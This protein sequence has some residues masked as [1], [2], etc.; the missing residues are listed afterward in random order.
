MTCGSGIVTRTRVC[1][2]TE[3]AGVCS[4]KSEEEIACTLDPCPSMSKCRL[5]I[6]LD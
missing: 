4:G 3:G 2:G 5:Y 6:S 1:S